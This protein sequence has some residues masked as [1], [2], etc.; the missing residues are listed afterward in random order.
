[1]GGDAEIIPERAPG[2]TLSVKEE[3]REVA[4][5]RYG[6]DLEMNTNLLL[7]VS[8]NAAFLLLSAV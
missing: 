2:R 7:C 1:M 4:L 3:E 8:I 6:A 5:G